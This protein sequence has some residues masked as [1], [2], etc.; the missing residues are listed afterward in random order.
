MYFRFFYLLLP[1]LVFS[2]GC[3]STTK[4]NLSSLS[5]NY[6][7]D[8][9]NSRTKNTFKHS[10]IPVGR[11]I[12]T[13]KDYLV[14]NN[15]LGYYLI[16]PNDQTWKAYYQF[17]RIRNQVFEELLGELPSV[18]QEIPIVLND[19][20]EKHIKYFKG[21]GRKNFSRWLARSG[22]FIPMMKEILQQKNLPSDL[23]YLAMIESGYNVRARS[24]MG[25]VGPWQ[26]IRST[27]RKYGL[28][29]D[30][31]VDERMNPEKSTVA[32]AN[33]LRDLF[34]MFDSWELAAAGYNAGE[35]RVQRAI[36]KYNHSDFWEMSR[37]R[38][39][40]PRETREYVPK[41]VAALIIAKNPEKYGFIGI[42]Y[43]EPESYEYASVP[44]QKS[45][46]DI[47]RVLGMDYKKLKDLNPSL[48]RK[49]TPPG[50][51]YNLKMP[52]GYAGVVNDKHQELY[53][54]KKFYTPT[55]IT[56][57]VRRG[58][59]LGGIARR[60]RTRVSSIQT[61]NRLNG[62]LIRIG[63]RLKIPTKYYGTSDTY[64]N[65][66]KTVKGK[67]YA[68]SSSYKYTIRKGDTLGKIA[69]RNGVN[70]SNL[71][72]HNNLRSNKIYPGQKLSIPGKSKGLTSEGY[73]VAKSSRNPANHT[74]R[75]GD[76]LSEIAQRYR[77]SVHSL[78]RENDIRGSNI[79]PGQV[80]RIPRKAYASKVGDSGNILVS[81]NVRRGDTLWDI[82]NKYDVSVKSIK[83]WNNLKSSKLDTG[84]VLKIY[85]R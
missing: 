84:E 52:V 54:L 30:S 74:V 59:T 85:V 70:I 33:Y 12:I 57:R 14:S 56:H 68:K 36:D 60:Y 9:N 58:D 45:L 61:A 50:S 1:I 24:S 11:S 13:G 37:S 18:E 22:K 28:R 35:M 64:A 83:H 46:K 23:V 53:A 76:T 16:E 44:A 25:A 15:E 5:D 49:A 32:A 8:G 29:I 48:I 38:Y 69:R 27:G 63:Q 17:F 71:K 72:R 47:S 82:A 75:R 81:H 31:W 66:T 67:S 7:L 40:L 65:N 73:K 51:S 77:V 78:K 39:A 62:S 20:V 79:K 19:K 6:F 3:A 80:L 4:T 55:Y 10:K 21:R 34:D 42:E 43:H 41:I 2:F 26:F